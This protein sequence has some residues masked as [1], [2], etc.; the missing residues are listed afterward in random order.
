MPLL[1]LP[2]E[3][4]EEIIN[5]ALHDDFDCKKA[6]A[7]NL[8]FKL[9]RTFGHAAMF[10]RFGDDPITGLRTARHKNQLFKEYGY[11]VK[12]LTIAHSTNARIGG[13]P[14]NAYNLNYSVLATVYLPTVLTPLLESFTSLTSLKFSTS[15]VQPSTLKSHE[16]F[17][18]IGDIFKLCHSLKDLSLDL[19]IDEFAPYQLKRMVQTPEDIDIQTNATLPS[20]RNLNLKFLISTKDRDNR[21]TEK[22]GVW[23]LTWMAILMPLSHTIEKF[24]YTHYEY[25][26]PW[27]P[28][29]VTARSVPEDIKT[30][31]KIGVKIA[32]PNLRSLA[33]DMLPQNRRMIEEYFLLGKTNVETLTLSL[34]QNYTALDIY[35]IVSQY[36]NL[37][38]LEIRDTKVGSD[39]A[40]RNGV[41]W[42]F[43][44]NTKRLF[45][46]LV[47]LVLYTNQTEREVNEA[48]GED[49]H[50]IHI[51][52]LRYWKR[53]QRLPHE[54]EFRLVVNFH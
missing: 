12:D 14:I 41:T 29:T 19:D 17:S 39:K 3:L 45:R 28:N 20:L 27:G 25:V 8:V 1:S 43:V 9:F 10:H 7:L 34:T 48:I 2:N 38:T 40:T 53:G 31:N 30:I 52:S 6:A 23:I 13:H 44:A 16:M 46:K 22:T 26:K 24:N 47:A 51:K 42:E 54:A 37:K 4:L 15:A 32:L 18:V 35:A 36:P 5:Y 33:L 21:Y 11:Y 49:L 50:K